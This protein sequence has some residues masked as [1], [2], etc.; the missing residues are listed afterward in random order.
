MEH[1]IV[2]LTQG[3]GVGTGLVGDT[4]PLIGCHIGRDV[5]RTAIADDEHRLGADAGQSQEM[6]LECQ[7]RLQDG[8]FA[9]EVELTIGRQVVPACEAVDSGNLGHAEHLETEV[10]EVFDD[11]HQGCRLAGTGAASEYD[12]F[13]IRHI[14]EW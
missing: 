4:L 2:T 13:D 3:I 8:P 7:L 9:L 1:S 12:S 5:H 11:A 6:V 10:V 14:D